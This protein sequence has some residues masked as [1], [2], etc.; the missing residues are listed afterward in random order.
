MISRGAAI[1]APLRVKRVVRCVGTYQSLETK[2]TFKEPPFDKKD[3]AI[4]DCLR[5]SC[6]IFSIIYGAD[7]P[8]I[9][10]YVKTLFIKVG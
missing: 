8:F 2:E 3:E 5:R 1:F 4:K 6:E 10:A 7:H 9:K